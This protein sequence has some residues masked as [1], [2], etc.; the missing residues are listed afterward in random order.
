MRKIRCFID[1]EKEEQFINDICGR[2]F[3]LKKI[4]YGMGEILPVTIYNF[5]KCERNDSLY[6]LCLCY[7]DMEEELY[8]YAGALMAAGAELIEIRDCW[9][10]MKAD[11]QS[12]FETVDE[13]AEKHD[14]IDYY[15]K[16]HDT[17]INGTWIMIM[18]MIFIL[19]A[20]STM[21]G[22]DFVTMVISIIFI[23][24]S[25]ASGFTVALKCKSKYKNMKE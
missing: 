2:G 6:K 1:K 9:L 18:A 14:R 24:I 15:N 3:A 23:I 13:S 12:V 21:H 7:Y 11:N 22:R 16:M 10:Y 19:I 4:S 5:E 20:R 8:E 17:F 25:G